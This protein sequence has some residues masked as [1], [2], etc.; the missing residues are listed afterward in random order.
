MG[1]VD[2]EAKVD[3]LLV[4]DQPANLL[5]L[6]AVLAELGQNLVTARGGEEALALLAAREFAAVLLDVQ[7]QGLDGFETARLIRG[8]ERSRP[9]PILFLTAFDDPRFPPEAA[10]A[11]GAVDYLVKPLVP[12]ILRAKVAVFIELFRETRRAAR[13]EAEAREQLR[14][15]LATVNDM[16]LVLDGELRYTYVNDRMVE[17]SGI[18]RERLVGRRLREVFPDAADSPL[19]RELLGVLERKA[20]AHFEFY[21][22]SYDRW[23]D[24]RAY[25]S[26]D[27]L[28][29]V[30]TEITARKRGEEARRHLAAI[31]ES[32][33]DAIISEDL[34]GVIRSWNTGAERLLG[35][36]AD[37]AIGRHIAM[38]AP[39][40]RADDT[41]YILGRIRRGEAI[42][43]YETRR[44]R[45]DGTVLDV[46]LTV[47]P[48]RDAA[49][50]IVGASKIARDV[51]ERNRAE[52]RQRLLAEAG[53]ILGSSLDYEATLADVCRAVVPGFA[54]WCALDLLTD[55][56]RPR[57]IH[58]AHKDPAMVELAREFW[59][60]YPPEPDDRH[61]LMRVLRTGE[62][63]LVP[64]VTD[65]MLVRGARD[66]EHL[67]AVRGLGLRSVIMV[68]LTAGG[69]TLG[70]LTLVMAE[71]SR[72]FAEADL[73][74]ARE[75]A[76]RAALAVENARL[77]AEAR[78]AVRVRDEALALHRGMEEQLTL[79]V[80]ASGSLSASLDLPSVLGAILALS[81]RLVAAD[82]YAVWRYRPESGRWGIELGSGLSEEYQRSTIAVVK[83][84][85]AMPEAAVV[86]EDV[87]ADRLLG[88]R[89][90]PYDREGIRSLMVVPL[91]VRGGTSG[92]LAFYYRSPHRFS[93]IEVRVATALSNLAGSAIGTAE[94]Y[95]ELR[96]NDRRKDEFLAMLAH[97]LRNPLSAISNAVRLARRT[98]AEEEL[99]WSQEVIERQAGK[100]ARLMDD[101]LDV[102]RITRGKIQLRKEALD[103]R[104]VLQSAVESV[105]PLIDERGHELTVSTGPGA[106]RLEADP[107]RLEQILINLLTNAAKYSDRG[108]HI[109]VTAERQGAE[110]AFRVQDDGMGIPPESLPTMFELFA[111]G[112]RTVARSEGG[113]GIGLTLV[114]KLAEMHGGSVSAQSEGP[115]KGSV[116]T[117]R[118]P[119]ADEG[120]AVAASAAPAG[121]A[122]QGR[123]RILVVDDN[124]DTAR[125]LARLLKLLGHELA[126]AY[127]GPSAIE[128]A[129]GFRPDAILLDIGLPIMSGYEVAARLRREE[130][131][132]DAVIIAVSGYGQ[133]EDRRRSKEAGFDDHLVKPVDLDLLAAKLCRAGE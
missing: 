74:L 75:L 13:A 94:L 2:P 78:E 9:T 21:H 50:A 6:E 65:E 72:R 122:G 40:D 117:V 56:G 14:H 60:R 25:P 61:G 11:L 130:C 22:A 116:F 128:A 126:I 105:R 26:A 67:R 24:N 120:A 46:S 87:H 73:G 47:S 20:P 63:V 119:A 123:S 97:E 44:R 8:R 103:A 23:F 5:A 39:P 95:Q 12:V 89:A 41:A 125:G 10:Y 33:D 91:R 92:T 31:V 30:T 27:G 99:E 76:A 107:M 3:L 90:G 102:S 35:Y 115:G 98:H 93:E 7:M 88:D 29:L 106:L 32:S 127:D 118:L 129:R 58:V 48:V 55:D 64:D 59:R 17:A 108:G 42:S 70:A 114:R 15:A 45:K 4:D 80:E 53:R 38:L 83:E 113:L 101:L 111:Q 132:K 69:R 66:E 96:D 68:P 51:T 43:H 18:P 100:L 34:D 112:E 57:R 109:R 121:K 37:E 36:A 52:Q 81:R 62:P 104:R 49:G 54:D 133:E 16:F 19:E 131:C 110:V 1:G 28:I 71:S 79:L 82:A 84:T 124:V 77:F 86:A 85:P